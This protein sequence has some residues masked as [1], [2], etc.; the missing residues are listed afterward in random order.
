MAGTPLPPH[1]TTVR[2]APKAAACNGGAFPF[3]PRRCLQV[4]LKCLPPRDRH[5]TPLSAAGVDGSSVTAEGTPEAPTAPP[6]IARAL[7]SGRYLALFG[8]GAPGA[9]MEHLWGCLVIVDTFTLSPAQVVPVVLEPVAVRALRRDSSGRS[10]RDTDSEG[11]DSAARDSELAVPVD[12]V[13]DLCVTAHG[14]RSASGAA[15]SLLMLVRKSGAVTCFRWNDSRC[16]WLWRQ[17]CR[18][19][20]ATPLRQLTRR[21][22]HRHELAP[23]SSLKVEVPATVGP[24]VS[25]SVS[26]DGKLGLFVAQAGFALV[27]MAQCV[28]RP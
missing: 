12:G 5:F 3:M 18:V 23:M 1:A 27:H 22:K 16:V 14:E 24:P 9:G 11:G 21:A 15:S 13:V 10:W 20:R 2:L 25:M 19:S 28:T 7:G 26:D 6:V 4:G 17:W 8:W